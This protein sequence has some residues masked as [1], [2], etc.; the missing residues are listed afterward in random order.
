MRT[1]HLKRAE[2]LQSGIKKRIR[3]GLT[4]VELAIVLLVLGI[5]MGIVYA[6]IDLGITDDAVKLQVKTSSK[7]VPVI[8]QRYE[9]EY[10]PLPEGTELTVLSEQDANNPGWRPV[11]EDA[12]KDP[13]GNP[14]YICSGS[15]GRGICSYGEDGQPGGQ[16]RAQDFDLRDRSTWPAWISGESQ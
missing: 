10:S 7:Q 12:V 15:R 9:M 5:I 14:Y 16:G 4:L 11:D 1:Y 6:N 3:R 13:W 2:R 8:L